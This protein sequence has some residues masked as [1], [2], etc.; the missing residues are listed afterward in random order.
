MIQVD[1]ENFRKYN[2]VVLLRKL[3]WT[4]SLSDV[5]RLV[6]NKCATK[7][8]DYVYGLLGLCSSK[9]SN[10]I[11]VVPGAGFERAFIDLIKAGIKAGDVKKQREEDQITLF[12]HT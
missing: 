5:V 12:C 6:S 1:I 11:Q 7:D 10:N 4:G 8:E 2:S 3:N 9:V